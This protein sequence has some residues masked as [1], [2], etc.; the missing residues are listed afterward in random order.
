MKCTELKVVVVNPLTEEQKDEI[1]KRIEN[2]FNN[3][4]S[5]IHLYGQHYNSLRGSPR[6]DGN[7]HRIYTYAYGHGRKCGWSGI[8]HNNPRSLAW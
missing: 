6:L 3:E 4:E 1:L 8:C 5:L 2:Y 7:T